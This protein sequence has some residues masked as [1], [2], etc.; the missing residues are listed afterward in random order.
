MSAT[1]SAPDLWVTEDGDVLAKNQRVL[2]YALGQN[3]A[4][5]RSWSR[6]GMP[7]KVEGGGYSVPTAVR[8]LRARDGADG[9]TR[10][11][12]SRKEQLHAQ[13]LELDI[14]ERLGQMVSLGDVEQAFAARVAV[15]TQGLDNLVARASEEM[16]ADAEER[17]RFREILG[18]HARAIRAG[19]AAEGAPVIGEGVRRGRGRPRKE[20]RA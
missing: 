7:A 19:F 8:W 9:D 10:E 6:D 14:Q 20:K 13:K 5:V 2:A 1:G 4:T 12:R 15:V 16:G 17:A 11:A 3:T 18:K